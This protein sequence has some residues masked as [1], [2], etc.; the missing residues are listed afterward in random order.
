MKH[1]MIAIVAF[2]MSL[3]AFAG[4]KLESGSVA[5]LA[6]VDKVNFDIE[7]VS[8][9]GMSEAEFAK[10]EK[11]WYTDKPEI[12]GKILDNANKKLKGTFAM[13]KNI[14]ANYTVKLVVNQITKKGNFSC[15]VLV[16]DANKSEIAKIGDVKA[17]GGKWGSKLNLIKDGAEGVGK[18]FG[19]VL[20]SEVKKAK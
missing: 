10:Y 6:G 15:D 4:G 5:A 8:I 9:H 12:V 14:S 17:K 3:N 13:V 16:L 19:S 2:F 7:F 1:V 20:K 11:D 18:E